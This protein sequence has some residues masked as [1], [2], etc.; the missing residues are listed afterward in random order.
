MFVVILLSIPLVAFLCFFTLSS[1]GCSLLLL[2]GS[3]SVSL[4]HW[5][6]HFLL[7]VHLLHFITSLPF[8]ILLSSLFS[9]NH[10][11]ISLT[12]LLFPLLDLLLPFVVIVL[13]VIVAIVAVLYYSV[14]F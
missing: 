5:H 3:S 4:C 12:L 11:E 10:R 6:L 7:L 13:V 2:V 14:L 8:E 1:L 9:L